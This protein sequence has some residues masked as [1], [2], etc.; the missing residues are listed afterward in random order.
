[1]KTGVGNWHAKTQR[2]RKKFNKALNYKALKTKAG[3]PKLYLILKHMQ[4]YT[5]FEMSFIAGL[6]SSKIIQEPFS[7]S[8]EK[9]KEAII[10]PT[11]NKNHRSITLKTNEPIVL[12]EKGEKKYKL[13]LE[14]VKENLLLFTLIDISHGSGNVV[15]KKKII[16]VKNNENSIIINLK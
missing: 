16:A 10:A 4:A 8:R 11:E 6:M 15:L 7:L 13:T 9:E 1:M 12:G 14:N 3:G 5:N 2:I